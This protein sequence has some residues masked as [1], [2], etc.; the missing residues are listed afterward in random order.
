MKPTINKN[1]MLI[2]NRTSS[3]NFKNN[4]QLLLLCLPAVIFLFIFNYIPMGGLI[5]AFKDF[6]VDKGLWG[7]EWVGL[8]NFEFFFYVGYCMA[9]NSQY[10]LL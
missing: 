8:K 1:Q 5:M 6:R 9:S 10:C 4:V 3:F 7:S 2:R